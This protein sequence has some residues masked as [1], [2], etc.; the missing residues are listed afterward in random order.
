MLGFPSGA[1]ARAFAGKVI[2]VYCRHEQGGLLRN[3]R[4]ER[5]G[6][7]A[8]LNG[9]I[10]PRATQEWSGVTCWLALDEVVKILVFDDIDEART[11][12]AAGETA[13]SVEP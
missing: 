6:G 13:S 9:Q 8:F 1:K 2:A 11:L 12:F 10:A 4:I 3:V 7:R 5:L